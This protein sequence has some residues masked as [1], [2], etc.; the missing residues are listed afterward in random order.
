MKG[1]NLK[2]FIIIAIISGVIGDLVALPFILKT[3]D[4]LILDL[5]GSYGIG[6]SIGVISMITSFFIFKNIRTN[7][8]QVFA[9]IIVIIGFGTYLGANFMG[10]QNPID[11]FI[12]IFLAELVGN[13]LAFLLYRRTVKLNEQ[14][15]IIQDKFSQKK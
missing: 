10:E 4:N 9:S 15:K 11:L 3:P 8:F 7:T 14:L 1:F 12:M 6:L 2:E 5:L 13:S